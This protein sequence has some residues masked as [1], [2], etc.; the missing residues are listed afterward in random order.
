MQFTGTEITFKDP[1][2]VLKLHE[3]IVTE[4]TDNGDY[5]S[6]IIPLKAAGILYGIIPT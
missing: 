5:L 3:K 6:L 1:K 4:S 2:T